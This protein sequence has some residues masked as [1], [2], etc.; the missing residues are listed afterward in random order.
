MLSYYQPQKPDGT[1]VQ[2]YINEKSNKLL[3]VLGEKMLRG[4]QWHIHSHGGW[5]EVENEHDQFFERVIVVLPRPEQHSPKLFRPWA[6]ARLKFFARYIERTNAGRVVRFVIQKQVVIAIVM[7]RKGFELQDPQAPLPEITQVPQLLKL[8]CR[9]I[10]M[11][12]NWMND[13]ELSFIQAL[14]LTL[15]P[16]SPN[17]SIHKLSLDTLP[18]VLGLKGKKVPLNPVAL[19][20]GVISEL[21]EQFDLRGNPE[22]DYDVEG[23]GRFFEHLS[24]KR[25]QKQVEACIRELDQLAAKIDLL[26]PEFPQLCTWVQDFGKGKVEPLVPLR[27]IFALLSVATAGFLYW[28]R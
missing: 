19:V 6:E 24:R 20:R 17:P 28:F 15:I 1:H 3:E 8:F 16:Q 18:T 27:V 4:A 9:E 26:Q 22:V 12:M 5:V 25:K 14:K 23:V 10:Q 7:R 13:M 11:Y 21:A 2:R